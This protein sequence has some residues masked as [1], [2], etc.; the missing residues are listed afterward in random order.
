MSRIAVL[1][2][3]SFSGIHFIDRCLEAGDQVLGIS[4]SIELPPAFQI[5]RRHTASPAL[6]RLDI[7]RDMPEILSLLNRFKPHYVVNF[8]AL[9]MVAPSWQHPE[10]WYQT[11][12]VSAARLHTGLRQIDSLQRFVQIS[13]PEVYGD[14]SGKIIESSCYR[15]TSP[16]AVSKAATDMALAA[17]HQHYGFP[18]VWT[19]SANVFG[20]AQQL[21]RIIPRAVLAARTGKRL[22]LDGGGKALRAFIHIRDVVEATYRAMTQGPIGNI[23]HL[24]SEKLISIRAL[25]ERIATRMD[26]APNA[27]FEIGAPRPNEDPVYDL[28]AN[29]AR[30]TLN[31]RCQIDLDSGIDSVIDWV[32]ANLD[33]LKNMPQHYQHCA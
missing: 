11:N 13:T 22:T 25:V 1:G 7:N 2:S 15:P 16:Y 8:A 4:R 6:H 26:T 9:G 19:R 31:W 18:V 14:V 30:K 3:S 12:F 33:S 17:D 24:S 27:L 5:Y 32:D 21:Y 28:D 29:L 23:Y 10:Q 20:P